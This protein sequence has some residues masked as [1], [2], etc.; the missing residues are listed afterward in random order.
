MI[1][2]Q[3]KS[4]FSFVC[5]LEEMAYI[6]GKREVIHSVKFGIALVLVTL[7]YLLDPL[8]ER[9]GEN[10]MWAIMTVVLVFEFF[11]GATLSKGIYR[12]IGTIVGG[13]L[14]C[15]AAVLANKRGEM[16]EAI[17]VGTSIFIFGTVA[18]YMRQLPKIKR[19]YDY[20]VMI[21]IL[22]FNLVLVSPV[23]SEII[24]GLALDRLATVGMGL[25]ICICISIFI[26]P[27][28]ASDELHYSTAFKFE[29]LASCID[30]CLEE[31]YTIP[32]DTETLQSTVMQTCKSI[33]HSKTNEESLANLARWEPWHGKF[34][35]FHPW[36]KYLEVGETLGELA[37][38]IF[39]FYGY[40][41][42]SKK[43]S[44]VMSQA[45]KEPTEI[46]M[47]S[48]VW[49]LREFG[50]SIKKMKRCRAS[51]LITPKLQSM[52][53]QLNLIYSADSTV[54][55]QENDEKFKITCSSLLMEIVAKMDLLVKE[56][57]G[58]EK[59]AKFQTEKYE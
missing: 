24:V 47:L 8:F 6:G 52:K 56:L 44:S 9:V 37:A 54:E 4:N 31:F 41:Q 12:G 36:E 50:E 3:K 11:A 40:L 2:Q 38:M 23:R 51:V 17:V 45:T 30:G 29:K 28:W 22:T 27:M 55:A 25:A 32:N 35:F 21:F 15:F 7:S 5:S 43:T 26:F 42:S 46:V 48:L 39:T 33:L 53:L 18:T 14:G 13:G 34:G 1:D 57:E 19:R 10:A 20:P 59:L 58:L 49:I 16:F